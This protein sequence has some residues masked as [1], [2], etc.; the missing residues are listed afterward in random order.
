MSTAS[1]TAWLAEL[2]ARFSAVLRT[3][4]AA[5]SGGLRP[6]LTSYPERACADILPTAQLTAA[7]RL[8]VYQGQYWMRLLNLLQE[9]YPLTTRL[10]GAFVFNQYAMQ[11]LLE[12]P[13]RAHDLGEVAEGFA[14]FLARALGSQ[15]ALLEAAELDAAF[16]RVFIAPEQPNWQLTA[17]DAPSLA[18]RRLRLSAAMT[19]VQEHWPLLALRSRALHDPGE[20]ALPLPAALARPQ[21]W[22]L[23]RSEAGVAHCALGPL[24]ARLLQLLPECSVGEALARVQAECPEDER[25]RLPGAIDDFFAYAARA[26]LFVGWCEA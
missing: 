1:T 23:H 20:E 17:A 15:P 3:P 18:G 25:E 26:N 16:R 11:F 2:Q 13:P 6:D 4:L 19:C 8:S 24:Q 9:Q 12:H 21:R 22:L 10:F 7:E 5:Q 14:G